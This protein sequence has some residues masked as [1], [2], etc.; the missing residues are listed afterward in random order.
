MIRSSRTISL[1]LL[2]L[3][4][5]AALIWGRQPRRAPSR[6]WQSRNEGPA[7]APGLV[8]QPVEPASV[9]RIS[10][11]GSEGFFYRLYQEINNDRVLAVAGGVTFY[12]VLAIFPGIAAFISLYALFADPITIRDHL[13]VIQDFLPADTFRLLQGEI[14][15]VSNPTRG[16][17]FTLFVPRIYTAPRTARRPA[18]DAATIASNAIETA[19][20]TSELASSPGSA[21]AIARRYGLELGDAREWL[22][23]TRWAPS[24]VI[25]VEHLAPAVAHLAALGLIGADVAP[26]GLMSVPP[27]AGVR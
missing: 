13:A 19:R 20:I 11:T 14:R 27:R 5:G 6:P 25:R 26:L 9:G 1:P 7:T 8:S 17:T 16:S 24:P 2:A 23:S 3:A 21:A 22:A 18:P 10:W 12:M 4:A 15:L